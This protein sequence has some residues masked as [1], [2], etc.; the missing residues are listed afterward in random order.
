[1]HMIEITTDINAVG[2]NRLVDKRRDAAFIFSTSMS[3][4][5]I[6]DLV[7]VD[8]VI[9]RDLFLVRG[10]WRR[11]R[12]LFLC[13]GFAVQM[14]IDRYRFADLRSLFCRLSGGLVGKRRC[15]N[16]FRLRGLFNNRRL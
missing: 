12:F 3:V 4:D 16:L 15:G 8:E 13:S 6:K 2:M 9:Y 10:L 7:V 5:L 11:C 1:M 14:S